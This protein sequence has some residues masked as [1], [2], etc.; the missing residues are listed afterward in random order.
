MVLRQNLE[1]VMVELPTKPEDLICFALYSANHVMN[2]AYQP[3][4]SKLGLTYPQYIT[5]AAL[6]DKD[7]QSVG[8]LCTQLMMETNT[9]TPILK[10]MEKNGLVLRKRGI[11]DERKVFIHL[12]DQGWQLQKQ[13]PKITARIIEETG[14]PHDDLVAL[15][16]HIS[17]LRDKMATE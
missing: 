8:D 15:V 9:L 1:K 16:K 5:L 2:R 17:T 11:A 10:R 13:S 4:L 7:G 3:H 14:L 12:T 6:W